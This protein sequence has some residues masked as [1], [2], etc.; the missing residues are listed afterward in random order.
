MTC[1]FLSTPLTI[2]L[3]LL[4]TSYSEIL[5]LPRQSS[6]QNRVH[7]LLKQKALKTLNWPPQNLIFEMRIFNL[8]NVQ[9]VK[10]LG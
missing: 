7:F 5:S 1:S 3:S 4:N 8:L 2:P 6:G 9:S 10:T